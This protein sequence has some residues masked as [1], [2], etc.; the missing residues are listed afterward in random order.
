MKCSVILEFESAAHLQRWIKQ[1][2]MAD[3]TGIVTTSA[4]TV[5]KRAVRGA[6]ILKAANGG[7]W[8]PAKRRAAS[9]R[10]KAQWAAW[11]A[12]KAKQAKQGKRA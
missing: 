8:T 3:M 12:K 11:R 6:K 2:T 1:P 4:V 10:I 9:K 7:G 5:A